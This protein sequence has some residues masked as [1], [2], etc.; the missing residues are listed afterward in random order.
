MAASVVLPYLAFLVRRA[1]PVR[2]SP[3]RTHAPFVG[4]E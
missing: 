2:Q 4:V 3:E 1:A